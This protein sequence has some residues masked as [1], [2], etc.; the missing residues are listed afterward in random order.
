MSVEIFSECLASF[1]PKC[2]LFLMLSGQLLLYFVL[3]LANYP[4]LILCLFPFWGVSIFCINFFFLFSC[5]CG[6]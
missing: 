1:F 4:I 2:G 3:L 5:T 6:M